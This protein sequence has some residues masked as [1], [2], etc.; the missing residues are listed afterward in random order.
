M[1]ITYAATGASVTGSTSL[2]VPYPAGIAAGH[3]LVLHVVNKYP[4]NGPS[5]PAGWTAPANNQGSGGS[6]SA[7]TDSGNVY[8]TFFYKEADG[9]ETGTLAVTIPGGTVALGRIARL[10]KTTGVWSV[11]AAHGADT[12]VDTAWSVT[13]GADPGLQT[14]DLLLV[15]SANNSNDQSFSAHGLSATGVT[16]GPVTERVDTSDN[17]GTAIAQVLASALVTSGASSAAPV[18]TATTT[19]ATANSPAGASVFLRVREAAAP[20]GYRDSGLRTAVRAP[21][22]RDAGA[23]VRIQAAGGAGESLLTFLG[24]GG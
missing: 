18:Y 15:G 4:P 14:D 11:A 10:T 6:G 13:A 12:T 5:T 22:Y 1:A 9:S 17:N 8:S 7:G 24:A 19:A 2:A 16:F 21:G 20:T 3:L 23:R